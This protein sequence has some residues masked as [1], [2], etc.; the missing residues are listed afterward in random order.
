MP[1]MI[2]FLCLFLKCYFYF[3]IYYLGKSVSSEDVNPDF[4][5][6]SNEINEVIVLCFGKFSDAKNAIKMS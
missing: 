5:N 2:L 1:N 6:Q 4:V 3:R